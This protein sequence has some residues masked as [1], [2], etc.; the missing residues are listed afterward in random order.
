MVS[1]LMA[2]Y[3]HEHYLKKA[4]E[5]VLMQKTNFKYELIIGEDCST[6]GSRRIV[7]EY[8]RRYPNIIK[9]MLNHENL[10]GRLNV[11]QI[12]KSAK[13]KYLAICEG[14]DYWTDPDKLQIQVDFLENHPEYSGCY[15]SVKIVD[16]E[17][18]QIDIG[19]TPYIFHEDSDFDKE[20]W[21]KCIL[22][23]QTGSLVMHNY[24]PHM[25]IDE[26]GVFLSTICNG[27]NKIVILLLYNGK[28][29]K[30]GRTMSCYRRS[31]TGDSWNAR[32][33]R[34]DMRDYFYIS[35]LERDRLVMHWLG[36]KNLPHN[37]SRWYLQSV[38]RDV[39]AGNTTVE[40]ILKKIIAYDPWMFVAL[41][42]ANDLELLNKWEKTVLIDI[43]LDHYHDDKYVIFG[44]GVYGKKCYDFLNA[45]G[46]KDKVVSFWDND[47]QKTGH[48]LHEILIEKPQA[49]LEKKI[50]V[51]ISSKK[52]YKEMKK[53]LVKFGY[54]DE[55][56]ID[57]SYFR[58][59][60]IEKRII[61]D[62]FDDCYCKENVSCLKKFL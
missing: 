5:G 24:Y 21:K 57:A 14:D 60:N 2:V 30:M 50:K 22:P 56:I 27:D 49:G 38:L 18:R 43:D 53:Q 39:V 33:R 13:G 6:D 35:G 52:N 7:E 15:H 36:I 8:Q 9:A 62:I 28:I 44:T 55:Q 16:E 37:D 42:I 32:I 23:G 34:Q 54:T 17:D 48:R 47:P 40:K 10:G 4:I 51:I 29:K 1:V 20:D 12:T 41:L 11:W 59:I 45:Y 19:P 26:L 61:K 3:N 25:R 46:A 58:P 31:Y